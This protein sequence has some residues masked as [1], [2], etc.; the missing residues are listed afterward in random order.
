MAEEDGDVLNM[1]TTIDVVVRNCL[2]EPV[3]S[4]TVYDLEFLFTLIRAKSVGEAVTITLG[5]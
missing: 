5:V 4:L 1:I 2:K 3:D